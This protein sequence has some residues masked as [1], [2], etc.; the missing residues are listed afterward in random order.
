MGKDSM[1]GDKYCSVGD[2]DEIRVD[3]DVIKCIEKLGDKASVK[4]SH[5]EI[6]EIPDD[7]EW[8]IM[9]YDGYESVHEKHRVW[10]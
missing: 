4:Y 10:E 5:I 9:E 7:V 3:K 2:R 1:F 8:E 6:V